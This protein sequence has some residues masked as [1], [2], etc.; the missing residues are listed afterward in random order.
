MNLDEWSP[1][2]GVSVSLSEMQP[3][4]T[5][6]PQL[7]LKRRIVQVNT[8]L[9]LCRFLDLSLEYVLKAILCTTCEPLSQSDKIKAEIDDP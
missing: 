2:N 9:L 5:L 1:M 3:L 8:E 6:G 7:S 4:V